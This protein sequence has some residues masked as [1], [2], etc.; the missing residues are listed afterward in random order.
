MAESKQKLAYLAQ[1]DKERMM[2]EEIRNNY[3]SYIYKIKNKLVDD[4]DAIGAVTSQE[5]R[6]ALLKS[7][8]DAEEWMYDDGYDASLETYTK[9]YNELTEPAEKI[10]FRVK[11]VPAR[12]EAI[13]ALKE[14]LSK[15]L[16]LMTKWETTMPQVTEEER[17]EV[18]S[19][20]QDVYKWIDDKEAAQASADP[21]ADPVFTSDE[22]PLQTKEIQVLVSKLSRKPKPAPKKEE[23]KNETDA[24]TDKDETES[25]DKTDSESDSDKESKEESTEEEKKEESED[26]KEG[27]G[28]DA[29][30]DEL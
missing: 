20:V 6:D 17:Q 18:A 1:Q 25:K 16:A 15:V 24:A 27:D 2:L 28:S 30:E 23:S 3:E 7:A 8:E 29:P 11:E 22:V 26:S 12:A 19:K 5:Q 13:A 4:E 10:F 9:K 14:K 21:T